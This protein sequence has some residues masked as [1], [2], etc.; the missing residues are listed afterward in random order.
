MVLAASGCRGMGEPPALA[1]HVFNRLLHLS[2][3][4]LITS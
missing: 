3:V 1:Q 2:E 4:M